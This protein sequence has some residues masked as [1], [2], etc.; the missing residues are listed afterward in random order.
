M[1]LAPV[2]Y[3]SHGSPMRVLEQSPAR[4]FLVNL[5]KK[6]TDI[7][8]IIIRSRQSQLLISDSF[9]KD[10]HNLKNQKTII[11]N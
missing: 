8:G 10:I 3:L 2:L 7:K 5:G 4:D 1:S 11:N 9:I 6:I